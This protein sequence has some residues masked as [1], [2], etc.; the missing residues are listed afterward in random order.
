MN[1]TPTQVF[2]CGVC[3]IFKITFSYRTPSVTSEPSVA[4]SVFSEKS[5][6][7]QLFCYVLAMSLLCYILLCLLDAS[8]DVKKVELVYS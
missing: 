3:E 4:A 8:F 5:S 2:S 6:I 1:R 7:Q